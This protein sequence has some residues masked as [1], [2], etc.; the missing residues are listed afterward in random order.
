MTPRDLALLIATVGGA[1][2][3]LEHP[4]G[5]LV[6]FVGVGAYVILRDPWADRVE[7]SQPPPS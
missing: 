6:L 3:L 1:K 5:W 7:K 2:A 4:L